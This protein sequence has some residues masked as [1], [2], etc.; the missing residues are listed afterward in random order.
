MKKYKSLSRL[1]N[2][3]VCDII[4]SIAHPTSLQSYEHLAGK[5]I[6]FV[7]KK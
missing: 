3:M 7:L 5:L 4:E 6:V 1:H 2:S